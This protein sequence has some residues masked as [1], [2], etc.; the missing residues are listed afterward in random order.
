MNDDLIMKKIVILSFLIAAFCA[1]ALHARQ[2]L[3]VQKGYTSSVE[4]RAMA[5]ADSDRKGHFMFVET[6]HG[7]AFGDGLFL[8]GGTGLGYSFTTSDFLLPLYA[9]GKYNFSDR[10]VSPFV[11]V[12]LGMGIGLSQKDLSFMV[13]PSFGLDIR[14]FSVEFSYMFH[15]GKNWGPAGKPG[16]N[17]A[18][19]YKLN[20]L[21]IS[22]GY[23]F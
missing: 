16:S 20:S 14:R 13:S 17:W 9:K 23:W 3:G 12:E 19:Y 4:L 10:P 11:G 7:Y 2:S 6:V 22:V 5:V 21:N 1:P 8:G 18:S 15:E